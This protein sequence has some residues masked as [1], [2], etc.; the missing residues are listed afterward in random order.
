MCN[1]ESAFLWHLEKYKLGNFSK[2]KECYSRHY[3]YASVFSRKYFHY[4]TGLYSFHW[5]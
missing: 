5:Y 1:N 3:H 4:G 2:G